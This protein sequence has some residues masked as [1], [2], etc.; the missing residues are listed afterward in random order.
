MKKMKML[1]LF[2]L[3]LIALFTFVG[4][5]D[6]STKNSDGEDSKGGG[7]EEDGVYSLDN[8]NQTKENKSEAI[9]GGEAT[10]ALVSQTAFDGVLSP[11]FYSMAIDSSIME[12]FT[13]PL[14]EMDENFSYTQD[15]AATYELDDDKKV[16]TITIRDNVNWHDGVPVTADDVEYTYYLLGDPDYEGTRYNSTISNVKGMEEYKA[17]NTDSISGIKV[18]DDKTIE[19]TLLEASPF[20]L[21]WDAP[22]PKHVFGDMDID[23]I[24]ESPEVRQNPIGFGPFKV[25][26]IVPGESVVL[27]KN[28]DYWR[29]EVT[30]DQVTLKIVNSSSIVNEIKTGGVDIAGFPVDQYSDND[31]L[32]NIEVLADAGTTTTFI[33]FRLGTVD[34]DTDEVIPDPTMKMADVELRK[35]MW[36]ALDTQ[37]IADEYYY[38]LVDRGTTLIPPYHRGFHD[39]SNQGLEYDPEKANQILDDAGYEWKDGEEYRTDPDGEEL[40]IT[41]TSYEGGDSVEPIVEFYLQSWEEI[42]LNVQLLNGRLLELNSFYD[43]LYAPSGDEFDMYQAQ[44]VVGSNPDPA[45][46]RGPTSYLNFARWQSDEG[47]ELLEKGRSAE[48]FDTD[49]LIDV[50]NDW[51]ELMVEQV[52]EFPT[53]TSANLTAVNERIV[54]YTV[55]PAEKIYLYELGVTQDKPVVDGE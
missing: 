23:E 10:V 47:N 22:I 45:N 7:G 40:E 41:F 28:E 42:G 16:W 6:D 33:G 1:S 30:L 34:E 15:G 13:D 17:G 31:D 36:H 21:I 44:V 50:Y 12:W 5:N 3:L 35:A 27:K 46:H 29:G 55:D 43:M 52:P 49:W 11:L 9:D 37:L 24:A 20:L 2:A 8:F 39:D 51:Q 38:G 26:H 53:V 32:T 18:I 54:N 19:I 48:A 25:D 4:C 14:L